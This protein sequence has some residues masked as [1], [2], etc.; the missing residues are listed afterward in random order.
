MCLAVT[1]YCLYPT[2][3]KTR[4]ETGSADLSVHQTHFPTI[5]VPWYPYTTF[6]YKFHYAHAFFT[7]ALTV[8]GLL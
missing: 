8:M 4:L 6:V 3:V 2:D 5:I 1:R 7:H